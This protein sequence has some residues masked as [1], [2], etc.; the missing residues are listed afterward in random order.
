MAT[1]PNYDPNNPDDTP[2]NHFR[3]RVIAILNR[4]LA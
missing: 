1:L 3:N 2:D 4:Y